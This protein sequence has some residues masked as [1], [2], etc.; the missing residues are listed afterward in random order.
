MQTV[1]IAVFF[2]RRNEA[3]VASVIATL[4]DHRAEF[5]VFVKARAFLSQRLKLRH[6]HRQPRLESLAYLAAASCTNRLK[7]SDKAYCTCHWHGDI[8][9]S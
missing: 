3:F 8:V 2:G 7:F 5:L 6:K 4:Q 1:R 9:Q